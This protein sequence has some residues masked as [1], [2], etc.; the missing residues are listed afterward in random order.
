MMTRPTRYAVRMAVFLAAVAIIAV[1]LHEHAE[2]FFQRNPPLNTLILAV[3]ALGIWLSFRAVLSLDPA[4]AWIER[5]SRGDAELFHE[6]G[7]PLL[8]PL[9]IVLKDATGRLTLTAV[10]MRSVLDSIDSR[11][12]ERRD[13]SRYLIA[14]L[15]FLG[16][17][18]TFWGLLLT[19][20]SVGETIRGLN[21]TGTEPA[22]MFE[23]LRAG[24]EAPLSGMGTAFSTS[25]FGLASSLVLGF[26]D[27]Q[28]SQ[29]QN[30]FANDLETWLSGLAQPES[31]SVRDESKPAPSY[32]TALLQQTAEGLDRL[33]RRMVRTVDHDASLQTTLRTIGDCLTNLSEELRT[34]N[35]LTDRVGETQGDA[36]AELTR[37]ARLLEQ[38]VG[39][40]DEVV[41][42][43]VKT[44][45]LSVGRLIEDGARGRERAVTEIRDEI[46]LLARTFSVIADRER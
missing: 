38:Q 6:T 37:I 31:D 25:L 29:A 32:V 8:G 4:V 7:P 45:E 24:L 36:K 22:Q 15:I 21:V 28:A 18:G 23:T 9:A 5:Y 46:R 27:L 3:L 40:L 19:A 11:L 10:G 12:D 20:N 34:S 1:A 35:R 42:A 17:L 44:L 13:T 43:Q 41:R 33:E 2:R 14:L 16:L 39:A 30:R 26:L